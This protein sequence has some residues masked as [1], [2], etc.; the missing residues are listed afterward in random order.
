MIG[1]SVERYS[2]QSPAGCCL[3]LNT[4]SLFLITSDFRKRAIDSKHRYD[5]YKQSTLILLKFRAVFSK[6]P[7]NGKFNDFKLIVR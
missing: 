6:R 1:H 4:G 7:L 2:K 3:R 5:S